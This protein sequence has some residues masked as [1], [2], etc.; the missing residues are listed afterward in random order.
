MD[1]DEAVQVAARL[2]MADPVQAAA[3]GWI[4]HLAE[5][6]EW[7]RDEICALQDRADQAP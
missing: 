5:R 6:L 3:A 4:G 7:A 2:N 1:V